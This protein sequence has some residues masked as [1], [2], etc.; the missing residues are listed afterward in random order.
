MSHM[1]RLLNHRARRIAAFPAILLLAGCGGGGG[2]FLESFP[3]TSINSP[4]ISMGIVTG[5]GSIQLNGEVIDTDSASFTVN[6]ASATEI[7]IE[8]GQLVRAV[9]DFRD[10]TATSVAYVD[11]VKGP[12]QSINFS[13]ETL[14]V[15]GQVVVIDERTSF[16][17]IS[18]DALVVNDIVDVSGLRNSGNSIVASYIALSAETDD[19]RVVGEVSGSG[20]DGFMVS[21]LLVDSSLAT[22]TDLTDGSVSNGD[23][24]EVVGA[25][26]DYDTSTSTLVASAL[27][28]GF[29]LDGA[30][31]D[32]V[33]FEGIITSFI[34]TTDFIVA[35]Q[36][37]DSTSTVTIVFEDDSAATNNDLGLNVTVEVEGSID[38][39]GDLQATRLVV[40]SSNDVQVTAT[41]EDIDTGDETV[42]L[43]G[44]TFELNSLTRYDDQSIA[45]LKPFEL[46]DI[47][48]GDSLVLRGFQSGNRVAASFVTREDDRSD[49][50]VRGP[51]EAIDDSNF[52]ITLLGT[53][54]STNVGTDFEDA[55]GNT[56]TR[57]E[58][59]DTLIE[60]D[61]LV[62]GEWDNFFSVNAALDRLVAE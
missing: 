11:T 19:Y 60:E 38:E 44:I 10:S 21:G 4:G 17:G 54:F 25:A 49:A 23:V 59:F 36:Q 15:L 29:E 1:A 6:G 13:N 47:N 58:F 30:E 7:D 50:V 2:D 16:N 40:K 34:S 55:N 18:F 57:S 8:P 45:A 51:I 46:A 37:V 42:E 28:D 20:T 48:L 61:D 62:R 53:E 35:D 12:V 24:V 3:G 56:V 39:D 52:R 22:V 41:V 14:N 32:Q 31:D 33:E 27:K 43:L 26:A 5:F 9:V